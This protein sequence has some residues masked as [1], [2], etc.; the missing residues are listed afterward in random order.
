MEGRRFGLGVFVCIFNS[1]FSKTLL[2]KR[3]EE[4]RKKFN[5]DWGNIGGRIEFGEKSIQACIREAKEEIGITL[6]IE[7]LKL[8]E[9]KEI[10]EYFHGVHAVQF[11]YATTM[12][13][14]EK[15][16]INN[17]SDSYKWFDLDKLPDRTIDSKDELLKMA[18]LAK[19][20]FRKTR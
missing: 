3:N 6:D 18:S 5:S 10:P 8:I 7:K 16:T 12:D 14:K 17:E 15:I 13:E 1:K 2:L 19:A 11:I 9:I 4:K 20:A